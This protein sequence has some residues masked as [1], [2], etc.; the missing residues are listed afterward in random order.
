MECNK[1]SNLIWSKCSIPI[2][3]SMGAVFHNFH[4][5]SSSFMPYFIIFMTF[6][7]FQI[8]SVDGFNLETRLP[9]VKQGHR[10]SYF[11]YSVAQH[12]IIDEATKRITEAA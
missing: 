8:T 10:N 6:N 5:L 2:M 12:I 3:F 1:F 4:Q 11:G 7:L 9:L